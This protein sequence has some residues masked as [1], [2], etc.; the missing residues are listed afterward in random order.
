MFKRITCLM[1]VV[2]VLGLAHRGWGTTKIVIVTN[3]P[4]DEASYTPFLR[5]LLGTDITVE[6]EDD[7]YVDPLSA[8]AKADLNA[9][10]LIIVSRRTSSGKFVTD[11][12]FW[13]G[14]AA[15]LVLHSSFLIGDDRWRWMPGGTQNVDVT[16]VGVVDGNDP[17][18]DG[19]TI[20]DDQVEI[21]STIL[22][23]VDVSNQG[24]V[25][26]G[27]KIATPAGS[28]KVMIARWAAGIEYYPG[29][30]HIAG[31]P[32]LFFGM[33]TDE[34]LPFINDNGKKM[35]GNAI[36]SILGRLGPAPTASGPKPA[37]TQMDVARDTV[38]SWTPGIVDARHDVYFGAV[39]QS[40]ND[41]SRANP[42]GVLVGQNVSGNEYDPVGL[43]EFGRTYYWR[44]DEV[45][46]V[47]LNI[48]KG[49]VWSF[50][51][52]PYVYP[53]KNV[54]ATASS[55][56][57]GMG[58]ENTVSGSG[59]NV[60]DQHSTELKDMWL[61]A[62][63]QPNWIQ[64]AFD[65]VYKLHELWVWN[66]NQV[67]EK[68]VGWGARSVTIEYSVDGSTWTPLGDVPEFA[69]ATGAA[70]Y[71]HNTTISFWGGSAK[72]V[73][74]SINSSWAG[75]PQASLSEVRFF[76]VP[77]RAREPVPADA[78]TGADP[79]VV[80]SWRAGREATVH[81]LYFSPDRQAVADGIALVGKP[82]EASYAPPSLE[83]GTT[84]YWKVVEVN[85]AAS[86]SAWESD[87]W[88]FSTR[89]LSVIDDFEGYTN[90]SPNRVFQTWI[91][92]MGFSADEFFPNG[93]AGN[94]TGALVGYDPT[95]GNI[96]ETTIVHGGKQA[97]PVE[98][99]NVNQPYYSEV[100]RTW[101]TPQDWTAN[102]A[103][104]LVLYVRGNP[105]RFAQT[106]SDTITMSAAGTDIWN[107]AD[108]FR[109]ASK[110]LNGNGTIIVKVNSVENT[111]AWVKAG[112]M[113]R[114][115]LA[116]GSR[117]AALYATP[118]NGVHFQARMLTEGAATSDSSFSTA[119][120]TALKAPVWIKLERS[121]NSF[122][123]FYSTDGVKWTAM[124]WNPQ[125]VNMTGN[126]YVGLALSS[127]VAGVPATAEFSA[128]STTG[129]VTGTWE[130]ADIGVTHPGN[131]P[132]PLYVAV[133]DSAGKV[134][135]VS[136]PDPAATTLGSW[137]EWRIAF[138]DF[139][140]V[141]MAGVKKLSIGAGNRASPKAGGTGMLYIDDILVGHPAP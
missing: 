105:V 6:A 7:K 113:I 107:T 130:V 80:L 76:Y 92:G 59:L 108:E 60:N 73:K 94:G 14:L 128:I 74:L 124:S 40:V 134:K 22:A 139:S 125:T 20:T 53:L 120:Q 96:M 129:S 57:V 45:N 126:I 18:F 84:Y 64:F 2:L 51:V 21:S 58:P 8:A 97:M 47:N 118:G 67:I 28:D 112:I 13:N 91:D 115:S 133:Q 1:L 122:S 56:E 136:H 81:E 42:Q 19:V 119:E 83:L 102:G 98:Y 69:K 79:G 138:G 137:Q 10:D 127:H 50:T 71:A 72:Y 24:S 41:A 12:P 62:G 132:S 78:A 89:P 15:P 32:R 36:L 111:N 100:E 68:V 116:P 85:E 86:P 95:G 106:S 26:N 103:D 61:S 49:D 117:F 17:V 30:G 140:G 11:I 16:R 131:D 38:L 101:P 88:S 44:V 3:N 70:T 123:G 35:L 27:K 121:G 66:S 4:S 93:N 23:G 87:V 99:N 43:L 39:T 25:G 33:R 54:V 110:R 109:F 90:N 135:V 9:A 104:T 65:K 77:V 82:S 31:G 46:A 48:S 75:V 5:N 37:N 55:E 52:E 141:N 29:S 63:V 114:E 34:F